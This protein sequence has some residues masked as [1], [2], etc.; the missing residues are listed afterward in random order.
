[1]QLILVDVSCGNHQGALT[2]L[3]RQA[4]TE[5]GQPQLKLGMELGY[6]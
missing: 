1:M 6:S 2:N 5:M 4:G 3:K